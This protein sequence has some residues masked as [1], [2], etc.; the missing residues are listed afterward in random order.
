MEEGDVTERNAHGK[1]I[2]LMIWLGWGISRL[3]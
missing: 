2:N 3:C 1:S